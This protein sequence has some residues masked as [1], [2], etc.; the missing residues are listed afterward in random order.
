MPPKYQHKFSSPVPDSEEDC[1][2]TLILRRLQEPISRK[3]AAEKP[4]ASSTLKKRPYGEISELQ[5][6]NPSTPSKCSSIECSYLSTPSTLSLVLTK[7]Q[8]EPPTPSVVYRLRRGVIEEPEITYLISPSRF[9]R[10]LQR[11]FLGT[12]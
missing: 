2:Q 9:Y 1:I 4:P 11:L 3:Q 7:G 12:S 10:S 6:Q 5:D 8:P